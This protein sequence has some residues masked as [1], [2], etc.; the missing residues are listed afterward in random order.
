MVVSTQSSFASIRMVEATKVF[1][2]EIVALAQVN[3]EIQPG[4]FV[5][6]LGPSGSGKSTFLR[7][8]NGL[9][10]LTS[11]QVQVNGMALNS[12][13]L[14]SVRN[15]V[16]MIFQH[17]NLI[18]NLSV[19]TNVLCGSLGRLSRWETMLSWLYLFHRRHMERAK[20]LLDSVGLADKAWQ[21]ADNLSGGQQQRVG[22][23]RALMQDPCILL[24]D[25]PVASLD[26]VIGRQIMDLLH[27]ISR[28]RGLTVVVNL[29]Q[30]DLARAYADRV[31][32]L[33]QGHLV[34]DGPPT[35]LNETALRELYAQG[36][37]ENNEAT[38][39]TASSQPSH[40]IDR[41]QA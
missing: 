12:H 23:A 21:R 20:E 34:F 22:I 4:E 26:P 13:N 29:H 10:P 25:E 8:I 28:Q 18:S 15:Q 24:A 36:P 3:L 19:M 32:G 6:I 14:R 2:Q 41:V 37:V 5:V 1:D 16:G 17:F 30:V 40:S 33:K 7:S 38:T 31:V 27:T 11:G 35:R 9:C 39:M